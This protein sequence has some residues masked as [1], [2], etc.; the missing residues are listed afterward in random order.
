MNI[1]S[2]TPYIINIS[3]FKTG[4]A[5]LQRAFDISYWGKGRYKHIWMKD[6]EHTKLVKNFYDKGRKEKL[7]TEAARYNTIKDFPWNTRNTPY[8]LFEAFPNRKFVLMERETE[9][10]YKSLMRW[11]FSAPKRFFHPHLDLDGLN[12]FINYTEG[13]MNHIFGADINNK[14]EIIQRYLDRNME[15]KE[16]FGGRPNFY[17]LKFPDHLQWETVQSITEVETETIRQRIID[18]YKYTNEKY[19]TNYPGPIQTSGDP[20]HKWQFPQLNKTGDTIHLIEGREI[21]ER[22]Y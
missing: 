18:Y 14:E 1:E 13:F 20:I 19:G 8:E 4:S 9:G 21:L 10:W 22:S 15:L 11:T 5:S 2:E 12:K 3:Q 6:D 7:M 16:F 17:L